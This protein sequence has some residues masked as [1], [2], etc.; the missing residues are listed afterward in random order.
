MAFSVRIGGI[1]RAHVVISGNR[2][3][4][5]PNAT[6]RIRPFIC[7]RS[8]ERGPILGD[9]KGGQDGDHDAH[10]DAARSH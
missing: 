8:H 4:R 2:A 1:V 5:A 9:T 7:Q 3:R 10:I 6:A